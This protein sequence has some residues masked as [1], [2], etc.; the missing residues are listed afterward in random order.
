[1]ASTSTLIVSGSANAYQ[2][3]TTAIASWICL[4]GGAASVGTTQPWGGVVL[5][6][7]LVLRLVMR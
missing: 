3:L 6:M 5:P 4:N 2:G 1:M 7:N